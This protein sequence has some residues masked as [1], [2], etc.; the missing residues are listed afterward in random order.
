MTN[1]NVSRETCETEKEAG[2]YVS[3]ETYEKQNR[4]CRNFWA[5]FHVKHR[6]FYSFVVQWFTEKRRG[7][8][9]FP[10]EKRGKN[11]YLPLAD[12]LDF[13]SKIECFCRNEVS[14]YRVK[15]I[16]PLRGV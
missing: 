14:A 16:M 10:W 6:F 7:G 8:N 4:I 15:G 2:C 13:I 5:M 1:G 11:F 9:F 3:R 12:K